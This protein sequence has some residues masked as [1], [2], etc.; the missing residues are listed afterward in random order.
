MLIE[1]SLLEECFIA[2][3]TGVRLRTLVLLQ[4]IVHSVLLLLCH[5]TV[6]ADIV[7]SLVLR[8]LEHHRIVCVR[9]LSPTRTFNFCGLTYEQRPKIVLCILRNESRGTVSDVP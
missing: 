3:R 4:M 7:S 2:V 1:S 5:A 9:D 6:M 8:V